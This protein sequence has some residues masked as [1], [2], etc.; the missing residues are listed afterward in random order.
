MTWIPFQRTSSEW[1]QHANFW[2]YQIALFLVITVFLAV[3]GYGWIA[4]LPAFAAG[5][6]AGMVLMF[7][8]IGSRRER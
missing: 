6:S 2:V 8:A 3:K 7:V 5:L 4:L 1:E